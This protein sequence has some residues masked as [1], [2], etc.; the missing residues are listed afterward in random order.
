[1]REPSPTRVDEGLI[2]VLYLILKFAIALWQSFDDDIHS[3]RQF[4]C[5]RGH[6]K[7]VLADLEFVLGHR[8]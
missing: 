8:E 3:T 6:R 5:R 2:E 4:F 7:Q 1:M